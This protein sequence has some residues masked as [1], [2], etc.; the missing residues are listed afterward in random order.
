[1]SERKPIPTIAPKITRPGESTKKIGSRRV[2]DL[3]P[4][5]LRPS[6]QTIF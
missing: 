2:T 3:L 6:K 4:D 5:I 1:M